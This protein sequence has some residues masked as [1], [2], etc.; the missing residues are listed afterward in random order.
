MTEDPQIAHDPEFQ[1]SGLRSLISMH[2]FR[3]QW[4][5]LLLSGVM[6]FGLGMASVGFLNAQTQGPADLG[7][8]SVAGT[9]LDGWEGQPL[10]GVVVIVR[11]TTLATTTDGQGGFRLDGVPPGDQV[12][13][14]SKSGYATVQVTEVRVLPGQV[15]RIDGVLRPEF[16]QMEEYEVTAEVFEEQAVALLQDRQLSASV[17][18]GIGSD[19][20]S[21]LGVSD[22][23]GIVSKVT[24]ATVVD[25]RFAVIRGLSDRYTSATLNGAEVPSADP[26]RRSAQLD[27]FPDS[28]IERLVVSKTFT[29][30]QPGSFTGGSVNIVTR[31]FPE[32]P[33]VS[34]SVGTAFNT[35]SSF[36][37]DFQVAPETSASLFQFGRN[38][39][40]V[41]SEVR[42]LGSLQFD[43]RSP[44]MND[45]DR[46]LAA[47]ITP[48]EEARRVE[49]ANRLAAINQGLGPA[50]FAGVRDR[51]WMNHDYSAQAGT[52]LSNVF[53]RRLGIFTSYN[54]GRS[55]E[56]YDGAIVNRY[57]G[58]GRPRLLGEELRSQ[59][60]S[61]MGGSLN[62]AYE[63]HP[64]HRIKYNFL[65]NKTI[66]DEVRFVTGFQPE[67]DSSLPLVQHQLHYTEREVMAHQLQGEHRFE[68]LENRV[69]WLASYVATRQDEPDYRFLHAFRGPNDTYSFGGN[70]LPQPNIPSRTFRELEENNLTF[71]ID[72]TQPFIWWRELEGK[73]KFGFYHSTTWRHALERT[74]SIVGD[75]GTDANPYQGDLNQYLR[76]DN[77]G[78]TVQPAAGNARFLEFSRL[79]IDDFGNNEGF[80]TN[81]IYAGYFMLDAPVLGWLRVIGGVRYET[82][83]LEVTGSQGAQ[84]LGSTINQADVLPAAGLVFTVITNMNVRLHYG[85]TIARPSFRE[86]TPTRNYDA[87]TDDLFLGN[88]NLQIS[89]IQNYDLRWE[90]F[91]RPGEVLA[92][93]L[94][95]KEL[96]GPIELEYT[97]QQA[98][99]SQYRNRPEATLY[100]AEFEARTRL[101]FFGDRFENFSIGANFTYIQSKVPLTQVELFSKRQLDPSTPADRPLF[102]QSPYIFNLDLSYENP[103]T[104]TG[105]TGVLNRTGERLFVVNPLGLDV[106]EHPP[107]LLDLILIQRLSAR[108]SVKFSARNLLDPDYLR[109]YGEG[110]NGLVFNKYKRGRTFGLSL[111]AQF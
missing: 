90:W 45:P 11:G 1:A 87:T 53:G 108:W 21:R 43:G 95:Y 84:F 73:F 57:F 38:T 111:S 36:N 102:D 3:P 9:I 50:G 101:D 54:Y 18:D 63:F 86:I 32:Q 78:Y 79:P 99:I 6:A 93:S 34:G 67:G 76:P 109:T 89:E 66:E 64:N 39:A 47:N 75:R 80:G 94:F 59:M 25:G 85:K 62:L 16:Y 61:E 88:P 74:F 5:R 56:H 2:P 100:G 23:A 71:R 58:D 8:G 96:T 106:Y 52:T 7:L 49:N 69:D 70:T 55:F 110:R 4:L 91:R 107:F 72:D 60:N 82:T 29:P 31:S 98:N 24:G 65:I 30:D 19:Q 81:S 22:A 44:R 92:V 35:Q 42:P 13:R 33:F 10:P 41:P 46:R 103:R 28:Q 105:I 12:M 51:S 77:L 14:F 26:Y 15:S 97:D 20:F 83:R 40:R 17:L 68:G 27:M 104:G 48:A 37:P